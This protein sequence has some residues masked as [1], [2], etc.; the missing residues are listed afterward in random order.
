MLRMVSHH[1]VDDPRF[2]AN[3]DRIRPG[4]AAYEFAVVQAW[5][6]KQ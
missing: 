2:T 6:G 5:A 1:W 3:I 4:L